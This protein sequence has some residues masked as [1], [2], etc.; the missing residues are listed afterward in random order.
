MK[1]KKKIIIISSIIV[2]IILFIILFTIFNSNKAEDDKIL[3]RQMRLSVT[4]PSSYKPYI[5]ELEKKYPNWEFKALYTNL[6]WK[7]VIAQCLLLLH[8]LSKLC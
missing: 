8:M 5:D 4:F 1:S 3:T 7:Y 2:L 6:D